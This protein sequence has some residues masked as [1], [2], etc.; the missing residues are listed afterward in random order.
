M[1]TVKQPG[2][3]VFNLYRPLFDPGNREE[4]RISWYLP[5][6]WNGERSFF[7]YFDTLK[8]APKPAPAAAPQVAIFREAEDWLTVFSPAGVGFGPAYDKTASGPT[9]PNLLTYNWQNDSFIVPTAWA[10]TLPRDDTYVIAM[11]VRGNTGDHQVGVV[12]DGKTLFN[13]VFGIEG[14]DWNMIGLQ[15]MALTAGVHTL[16]LWMKKGNG[17]RP[18]DL[19]LVMLTTAPQFLPNQVLLAVPGTGEA[20]K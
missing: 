2:L 13:G 7:V 14:Q 17:P 5:G 10:V 4:G 8:D 15:P 16:E 12:W 6:K 19:D 20:R 9:D 1:T 18:L 3:R 11:R